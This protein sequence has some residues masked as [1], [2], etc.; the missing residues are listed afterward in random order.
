MTS[1]QP[2]RIADSHPTPA[3]KTEIARPGC[4]AAATHSIKEPQAPRQVRLLSILS[5][6]GSLLYFAS[7][8]VAWYL[9]APTVVPV[10][11]A[12][13]GVLMAVAHVLTRN[14]RYEI[15]LILG[16]G[17][18]VV[19][20]LMVLATLYDGS[21][22]SVLTAAVWA[23]L[24][25]L[26]GK[27]L[28]STRGTMVLAAGMLAGFVLLAL[29]L[30][31]PLDVLLLPLYYMAAVSVLVVVAN[32]H[33]DMLEN[34]RLSELYTAN[35]EL[36]RL[37]ASLE[38]KVFRRTRDLEM[39]NQVL[40]AEIVERKRAEDALKA[41]RLEL[42]LRVKDRTTELA[43]ANAGLKL[44]VDAH[45]RTEAALAE[46][47]TR[48]RI[49]FENSPDAIALFDPQMP[50]WP[51][52][53]CNASFSLMNGYAKAEL[54]GQPLSMI[55][56]T[57]VDPAQLAQYV[58]SI[59]RDGRLALETVHRR[60]DGMILFIES[61]ATLVTL[62][63]REIVLSIDRDVTERKQAE[64]M[65]RKF[66][67]GIERSGEAVFITD[68]GG[69]ITYVNPA[70]EKTYGFS[71][72]EAIGQN[73]RILKSGLL[74]TERYRDFWDT[75][76][77]KRAITGGL[78]NKAKDGRLLDIEA[79]TNPILDEAGEITGFLSIQRDVSDR[80]Q[81]DKV[82]Q[83][84]EEQ[85]RLLF[86]SNPHPMWV[87]DLETL[88]FLA[89]NAAAMQHYGYTRE[90]FLNMTLRDIRPPEDIPALLD[91][92]A[93]APSG[94]EE[95]GV[96]RHRKKDG[97]IIY[98]EITSHSILFAGRRAKTVLANDITE[99]RRAEENSQRQ[100]MRLAALREIDRAI[101]SS[102]ELKL[103]LD[104]LLAQ[105][106]SQLGVDAA[107]V[108]LLDPL[109]KKLGFVAG[110]GLRAAAV[111]MRQVSIGKGPAGRAALERR[112]IVDS[113]FH[114][115]DDECVR[116]TQL[117]EE[118]IASCFAAPLIAKGELKGVIEVFHRACLTPDD[119]WL[120]YFETLAGQA[121]IA[122]ENAEML[123]NLQQ[124]H[125]D[126]VLAYDKTL[127]GWARALDLR[128][129][130]T[131]GH[132][133]RVSEASVRL[134]RAVGMSEP[135]LVQVRR[136]ALLHDIGKIGIPDH[137]LLKPGSLTDEEWVVMRKHPTYAFEMLS[138]ID[139]L[140]PALDIPYCHHEKWDGTGYPR[141]L[142]GE[143]IPLVARLF[144]VV[145]VWDALRSDR[146]YRQAWPEE[147][148][149]DHIGK[150]SGSHFDPEAVKAFFQLLDTRYVT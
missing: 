21:P 120:D 133:Q 117:T 43:Q 112:V 74:S 52:V 127:E 73:P 47:E 16:L 23:A 148:V 49:L 38:T 90:E 48:F 54:I 136:G 25:I 89:V 93:K 42:E 7:T 96:W 102:S 11:M 147:R 98:V 32:K 71:K 140:R 6:V 108:L 41:A 26:I 88:G 5:L 119:E 17:L 70:F 37:R 59:R 72:A 19:V 143:Q 105:V 66:E 80:K 15:A 62:G 81:A 33:R 63:G 22:L 24:T 100:L 45:K 40:N 13:T 91:S 77:A 44:E 51:F 39:A 8:L 141:R 46:S 138:P 146:P 27:L 118:G 103:T 28:L 58:A 9:D 123:T 132:T 78:V 92:V 126:L 35:E 60:K 4:L 2:N 30:R 83:E 82:L 110:H 34:D 95:S 116:I 56:A 130:E 84:S 20:P 14:G 53:D 18:Q 114:G 134:A 109:S 67:L 75:I 101:T 106:T 107:D 145:D 61:T 104:V 65:R 57:N 115:T 150:G 128:D 121:S 131:E 36:E 68:A 122:I 79:S 3:S 149:H 129:K 29:I 50:Q 99:R 137:V 97:S 69:T 144:A 124:S 31:I 142:K 12:I 125:S 135:D 55:R 111:A 76:L 85:Y 86:E 64:E 139:Y 94:L 87:Y 113:H 1:S 10:L